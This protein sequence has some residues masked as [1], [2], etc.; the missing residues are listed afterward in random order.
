MRQLIRQGLLA[1]GITALCAG[2][3]MQPPASAVNLLRPG[4]RLVVL[5]LPASMSD[6][7]LQANR[8]TPRLSPRFAANTRR[9]HICACG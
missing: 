6:Q 5:Q 9:T 4:C 8:W 7:A 2:C 1:A 3:A